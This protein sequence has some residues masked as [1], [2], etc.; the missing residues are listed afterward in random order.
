MI[1][2]PMAEA[3]VV[4]TELD[5][6]QCWCARSWKAPRSCRGQTPPPPTRPIAHTIEAQRVTNKP[7]S[8]AT[9]PARFAVISSRGPPGGRRVAHQVAETLALAPVWLNSQANEATAHDHRGGTRG[10]NLNADLVSRVAVRSTGWHSGIYAACSQSLL[11][12]WP[13][14]TT[15]S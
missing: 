15:R 5:T 1:H 9:G 12:R 14:T 3:I 11:L 2:I 4:T 7:P 10:R 8:V 6:F 13:N